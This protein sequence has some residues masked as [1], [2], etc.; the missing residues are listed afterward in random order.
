ML[1]IYLTQS[2]LLNVML[3]ELKPASGNFQVK[4]TLAY[5]SQEPWIYTGSIRQNILCGRIYDAQYD[6]LE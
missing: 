4:G 6:L 1:C 5:A 2:S 3:G